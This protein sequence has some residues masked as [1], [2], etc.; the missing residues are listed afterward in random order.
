MVLSDD[1]GGGAIRLQKKGL[2]CTT[3]RVNSRFHHIITVRGRFMAIKVKGQGS[4]V[5]YN[6]KRAQ[7][8]ISLILVLC[9]FTAGCIK[10]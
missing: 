5:T 4:Y 7:C 10:R 3:G 1:A 8:L 2:I 9:A 6:H